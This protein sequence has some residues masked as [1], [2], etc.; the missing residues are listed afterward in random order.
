MKRIL[1]AVL[2][3]GL[4]ATC[5]NA[6]SASNVPQSVVDAW[7][8][9]WCQTLPNVSKEQL[10]TIM[11]QPT[12]TFDT[13]MSWSAPQYKYHFTAFFNADGTVKQLEIMDFMLSDAEKA[14]LPCDALRSRKSMAQRT[15]TPVRSHPNSCSLVLDSEMSA[16]LGSAVASEGHG[17][18]KCIYK[19]TSPEAISPYAELSVDYGNGAAA[20]GGAAKAEQH[21]AGISSHY[22]GIGDQAVAAGPMLMIC[23]GDDLMT[24][25]LSGVTDTET[26]ANKIFDTAKARMI[27]AS[28]R[29]HLE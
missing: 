14:A 21:E 3:V 4:T 2:C 26:A 29:G 8:T 10:V 5:S 20:M 17:Q 6:N 28:A 19:P 24:I 7:P 16:I 18:S 12:T 1:L 22:D 27:S 13:Q 23:T 15:A 9:K 25:V 11:G